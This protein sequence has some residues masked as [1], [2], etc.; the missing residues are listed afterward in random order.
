MKRSSLCKNFLLAGVLI[1]GLA[2]VSA[3]TQLA[4]AQELSAKEMQAI[5]ASVASPAPATLWAV[6]QDVEG[7]FDNVDA[8]MA[9]FEAEAKAQ[10]I[11][12]ANPTGILILYEDPT[13]KSSFRM[14][15]GITISR[16]VDVKEPLKVR[17]WSFP[18]VRH[19]VVGPYQKLDPVGRA[20][21]TSLREK[22][23]KT[24]RMA[25]GGEAPFAALRLISD[26]KRVKP[27]MLRT[28]LIVPVKQ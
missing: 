13:G 8:L 23:P 14:A 18:A 11:P 5:R 12:N 24:T 19:T 1:I 27:E 15:V 28:E 2:G 21:L 22:P 6:T 9:K 16:K 20:V 26:P 3:S 25:A 10:G 17:Q 4:R 7:N